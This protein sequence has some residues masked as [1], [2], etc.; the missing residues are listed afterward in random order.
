MVLLVAV[1]HRI[2]HPGFVID[3]NFMFWYTFNSM[4]ELV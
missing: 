4:R 1:F 3:S 2:S